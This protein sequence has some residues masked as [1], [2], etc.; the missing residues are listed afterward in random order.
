MYS[1]VA[2]LIQ[3]FRITLTYVFL[4]YYREKGSGIRGGFLACLPS[5]Y[6]TK[7]PDADAVSRYAVRDSQTP[8]LEASGSCV[9]IPIV[10]HTLAPALLALFIV[11]T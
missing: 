9:G 2:I 6:E 4:R 1:V 5:V 10:T 7:R 8:W 3:T 11:R